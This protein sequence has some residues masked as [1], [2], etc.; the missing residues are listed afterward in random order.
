MWANGNISCSKLRKL[1]N[2]R[3]VH[4]YDKNY[5]S[6]AQDSLAVMFDFA[7]YDVKISL[8]DFYNKFLFSPVSKRFGEGDPFTL[9]GKSGIELALDVFNDDSL[10]SLYH[11]VFDRSPEFWTGWALAYFQWF[12]GLKF[13]QINDLIPISEICEMYNPYHEMDISQFCD[14]MIDLYRSRNMTN[15]KTKRLN[16]NLSQKELSLIAEVPIRTIQQYEQK[17]KNINVAN[18]ETL[19][20]LSRTLSC[21]VEDLMEL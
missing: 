19:I 9:A 18:A 20:K 15:L 5:L 17:Q 3:M 1:G 11:P 16:A 14:H 4:S 2:Y 13:Q 8:T 12:T 6:V 7:V 21:S 10:A